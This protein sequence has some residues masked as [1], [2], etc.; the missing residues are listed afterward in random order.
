MLVSF[1]VSKF[2]EASTTT[3]CSMHFSVLYSSSNKLRNL[4]AADSCKDKKLQLLVAGFSC[5]NKLQKITGKPFAAISCSQKL[6]ELVAAEL[7]QL[8]AVIISSN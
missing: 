6:R 2:H 3:F 1:H 4:V 5:S 7:Q 8:S